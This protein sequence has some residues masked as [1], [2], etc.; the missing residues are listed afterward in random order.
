MQTKGWKKVADRQVFFNQE[1]CPKVVH[2]HKEPKKY[3]MRVSV[4]QGEPANSMPQPKGASAGNNNRPQQA[5]WQQQHQS[6]GSSGLH[7]QP[8]MNQAYAQVQMQR[9]CS[10]A[11]IA[12]IILI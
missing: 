6:G 9:L 4:Q 8:I 2:V 3:T 5:H 11:P 10:K 1:H 12:D 7:V